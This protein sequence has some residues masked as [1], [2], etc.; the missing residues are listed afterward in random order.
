MKRTATLLVL[1][2]IA[3]AV[4]AG[5]SPAAPTATT[6][7]STETSGTPVRQ[8]EDFVMV[9]KTKMFLDGGLVY[10]P[11]QYPH[12][13]MDGEPSD[14]KWFKPDKDQGIL[15]RIYPASDPKTFKF[16]SISISTVNPLPYYLFVKDGGTLNKAV[17]STGYQFVKIDDD[18][19]NKILPN[20]YL[21]YYDFAWLP[22]SQLPELWS[23]YE[24]R[25]Q[26]LWRTGNDYVIVGAAV[27][28]G[29][30]LLVAPT[31]TSLAELSGKTV[32]IMS[33]SFDTE[34]ALNE[35]LKAKGLATES[36][37][38]DVKIL[39]SWP[40]S[41]LSD[42]SKG[43]F[44]AAVARSKYAKA[45]QEDMGFKE[46]GN[47]GDVWGGPPP[48]IVLVVR[49]DIIEKHPDIV[50]AVVQANYD[51]AKRANASDEWK[52]PAMDLLTAFKTKYAG[53]P[54]N[55]RLPET[56]TA[57]A[58]P[59]HLKGTYDYMV[60]CGYFKVPY[61]YEELVDQSFYDKVK[62]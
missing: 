27:A 54:V 21:G 23:G 28:G 12:A 53:P 55:V 40:A 1:I 47:T 43:E 44:S 61:K 38:G 25:Q 26:E 48:A 32:G 35:M 6:P 62:K 15:D 37:G 2:A 8:S 36:A 45:L 17:A 29:D 14:N 18:G 16:L 42:L 60:K 30:P 49:R 7:G 20:A 10:D 57:L 46:L 58:S 50:Q 3:T 24:S 56:V 31:I 41:V 33:P 9:G 59:T 34:A 5:C 22:M 4:V 11:A 39:M 13:K 51:A 19:D 52:Q